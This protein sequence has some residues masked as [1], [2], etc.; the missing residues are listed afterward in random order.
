MAEDNQ[1]K[2]FMPLMRDHDSDAD[3]LDEFTCQKCRHAGRQQTIWPAVGVKA[4]LIALLAVAVVMTGLGIVAFAVVYQNSNNC[5]HRE[6]ESSTL[7]L[8]TDS[9]FGDIPWRRVIMEKDPRYH[10]PTLSATDQG[11]M[12]R[13]NDTFVWS[14]ILPTTMIA[15]P[16]P[17]IY[18]LSGGGKV[19]E[20][21][22]DF[23]DKTEAWTV[24]VMHQL[25]CLADFKKNFN[26]LRSGG[27]LNDGQ[28]AHLTH[29]VEIVRR[30]V[31]CKA[32]LALE[33]PNDPHIWPVQH[34]SGW[35]NAHVCR[36]WDQVMAAIK[37]YAITR[38]EN[39]WR[40][41]RDDDPKL[42]I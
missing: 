31:M 35:G 5:D 21:P 25:H 39:G 14:D 30:N 18:G 26:N 11:N 12:E 4:I 29:C 17:S 23:D 6:H 20:N 8:P 36:D 19:W 27:A 40:R 13:L 34:V 1:E 38:G 24:S 3:T 2:Q 9:L 28:Y 41:I 32:E 16:D 33:R 7:N 15:V 42:I 37:K 22:A 10:D